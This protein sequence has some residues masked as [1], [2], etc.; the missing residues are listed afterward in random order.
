MTVLGVRLAVM[1][2]VDGTLDNSNGNPEVG[3]SDEAPKKPSAAALQ[4]FE[5][6]RKSLSSLSTHC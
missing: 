6:F 5:N 4:Q 2:E 1:N 3:A